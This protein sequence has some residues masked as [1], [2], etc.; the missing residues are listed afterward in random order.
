[1]HITLDESNLES[2]LK[3][4]AK[5]NTSANRTANDVIHMVRRLK[6]TEIVEVDVMTTN[7]MKTVSTSRHWECRL[8]E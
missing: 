6:V 4:A 2:V 1:M 8:P 3:L 7:G 5:R